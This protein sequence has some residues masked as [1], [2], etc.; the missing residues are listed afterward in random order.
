ML[1]FAQLKPSTTKATP[2]NKVQFCKCE[3]C[4]RISLRVEAV[5]N[6]L[7]QKGMRQL[8]IQNKS[9]ALELTLCRK[10]GQFNKMD[11]I[12]RNCE[13]CGASAV[14]RHLQDA[15]QQFGNNEVGWFGRLLLKRTFKGVKRKPQRNGNKKTGTFME[16]VGELEADLDMF[17]IHVFNAEWQQYQFS[18]IK[19]QLPRNCLLT[20]SD[21]GL[22]YVCAYQEIQGAHWVRNEATIQPVV[23]FYWLEGRVIRETFLF[24]SADL[25][26]DAHAVQHF[27]LS[28]IRALQERG[29]EIKKVFHFSDGAASQYKGRTNF[30]DS[31]FGEEDL[32]VQRERH[33]FG[34]RHGKGP[35]DAEIGVLKRLARL[36]VKRRSAIIPDAFTL[37]EWAKKTMSKDETASKRTVL[38]V[39]QGNITRDRPARTDCKALKGSRTLHAVRGQE[40]Y[41]ISSRERSCFCE[42]CIQEE[43][44][45]L[46]NEVCGAWTVN[47][48]KKNGEYII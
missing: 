16:L 12:K 17:A 23:T 37:F 7:A 6:F 32:G 4:I 3:I 41:T 25:T 48:L 29:H 34:S 43:G 40:P 21:F 14:V 35:C 27:E 8:T 36:A 22:N 2:D 9:K 33:Y 46:N 5:N 10:D 42:S 1:P 15:C 30:C 20:V 24:I 19:L 26:H 18:A 11:C 38:F 44:A 31:S 45:C 39:G 28:T 13:D 47:Q